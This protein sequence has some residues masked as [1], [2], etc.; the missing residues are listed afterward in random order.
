M[1]IPAFLVIKVAHPLQEG[2]TLG[3]IFGLEFYLV[4]ELPLSKLC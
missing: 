3:I 4:L 2:V 1:S